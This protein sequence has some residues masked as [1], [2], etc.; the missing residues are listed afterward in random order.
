MVAQHLM[1]VGAV[2]RRDMGKSL[3][4][5][6]NHRLAR[7]RGHHLL[8][9]VVV[10]VSPL[11]HQLLPN[12]VSR[13]SHQSNHKLLKFTTLYQDRTATVKAQ[14][15]CPLFHWRRAK[16]GRNDGHFRSSCKFVALP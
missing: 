7:H 1:P 16:I 3:E 8:V 6:R 2:N 13:H 4:N 9:L 12:A 5:L 10:R 15:T 14:H 11:A